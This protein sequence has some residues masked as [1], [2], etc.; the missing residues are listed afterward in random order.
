[1]P[2]KT[3]SG[4]AGLVCGG[5]LGLL[6]GSALGGLHLYLYWRGG[7]HAAGTEVV[8]VYFW[9]IPG[10]ILGALAGVIIGLRLGRKR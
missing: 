8:L 1:M 7:A 4:C 10:A 5:I 2:S 3:G 6:L 9:A